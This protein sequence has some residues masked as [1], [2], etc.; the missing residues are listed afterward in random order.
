MD[1]ILVEI[2][3]P[4]AD[5]K[6]DA[7]IPKLSKGVEVVKI[8]SEIFSSMFEGKYKSMS[9]SVLCVEKT[10]KELDI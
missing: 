9:D 2:R 1:N 6:Y 7:L 5:A 10:G 3:I 8:I 4:A